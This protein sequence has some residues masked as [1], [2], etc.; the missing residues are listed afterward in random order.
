MLT[1]VFHHN[2]I[3]VSLGKC[4]VMM[5]S[6]TAS[7][8][9]PFLLPGKLRFYRSGH[10][11]MCSGSINSGRPFGLTAVMESLST[12]LIGAMLGVMLALDDHFDESEYL[13]SI[14]FVTFYIKREDVKETKSGRGFAPFLSDSLVLPHLYRNDGC[15]GK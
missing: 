1:R 4:M 10:L 5:L 3:G 12:T 8:M 2:H 11:N 14:F 15:L 7:L 6:I 9:L 13:P